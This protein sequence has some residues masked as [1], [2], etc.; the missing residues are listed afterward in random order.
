[1]T[2]RRIHAGELALGLSLPWDVHGEAGGLLAKVGHVIRSEH[3]IELLLARGMIADASDDERRPGTEAPSAL[4]ML[5]R[6]T[7]GLALVLPAIVAGQV[8]AQDQLAPLAQLVEEA[9]ALDADV[10]LACILH[11]QG[12]GDF[13]VRH[14]VDTAVIATMLARAL[15]LDDAALRSVVLAALSMNVGMLARH[16][17]FQ[18][19]ADP[20]DAQERAYIRAHPQAGV[21]LLRAAGVTDPAWLQAVLQHHENVDG[22]GYPLGATGAE[23]GVGARLIMLADRYCARV[24]RRSYRKPLLPNVALREMLMAEKATLDAPLAS[25]LVRELGIYPIGTFVKLLNGEIGVVTRKGLSAATPHVQSLI[26][27]RGARLDVP[28]RRDT[29]VDLHAIREVLSAEQAGLQFR[30]D[31]LWGRSARV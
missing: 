31:Q 11:N 10:A 29:R 5:N 28:L 8:I 12:A 1:M 17:H 7:S 18:H 20:L 6:A 25:L 23:I 13:A 4:R 16:A 30:P 27:P 19:K 26:G 15:K 2:I 22:S 3:Q 24:S 21:D 14:S 9:V